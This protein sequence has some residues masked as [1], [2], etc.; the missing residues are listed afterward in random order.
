M[1]INTG[2]GYIRM[3]KITD[4]AREKIQEALDENAGKYLRLFIQGIG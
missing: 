2:R 1:V 4:L 3:V